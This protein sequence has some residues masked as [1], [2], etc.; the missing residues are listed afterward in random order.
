MKVLPLPGFTCKKSIQKY[1]L[2]SMRI[3]VPFLMSSALI[4]NLLF[5]ELNYYLLEK[6]CKYSKNEREIR[7]LLQYFSKRVS[8]IF[9]IYRKY[10]SKNEREISS[11]LEYFTASAYFIR[12]LS[13]ISPTNRPEHIKNRYFFT[14]FVPIFEK[15]PYSYKYYVYQHVKRFQKLNLYIFSKSKHHYTIQR[16]NEQIS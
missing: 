3:A 9:A 5:F 1:N 2:P 15:H 8:I 11:L 12:V 7:S 4:I 10:R 13:Q 6:L 14:N 16:N